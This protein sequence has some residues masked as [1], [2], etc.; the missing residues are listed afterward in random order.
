MPIFL[1][2]APRVA[3]SN[4]EKHSRAYF[5]FA[6]LAAGAAAAFASLAAG[7]PFASLAAGAAPAA[8]GAPGAPAAAAPGTAPVGASV[9][10][11]FLLGRD[12]GDERLLGGET[13]GHPFRKLQ[14][15]RGDVLAELEVRNVDLDLERNAIRHRAN[16]HHAEDLTK[17]AALGD[18]HGL[19]ERD[20][21]HFD[22]DLLI[23]LHLHE[24]D[25]LE[26]TLDR[27]VAVIAD[28]HEQI[29]GDPHWAS[30]PPTAFIWMTLFLPRSLFKIVRISLGPTVSGVAGARLPVGDAGDLPPC[31]A[32][33]ALRLFRPCCEARRSGWASPCPSGDGSDVAGWRGWDWRGGRRSWSDPRG[34]RV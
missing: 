15:L 2:L 13:R 23:R 9:L 19:A 32:G 29:G 28:H 11:A 24:V 18:A 27:V 3:K 30:R 26:V 5:F 31:D 12:D 14:I 7:A 1:V 4:D 6:S 33:G 17:Q 20:E 10:G 21:R 16:G 25:V 8:A 34:A 22:V